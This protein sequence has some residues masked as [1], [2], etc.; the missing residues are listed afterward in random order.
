MYSYHITKRF[1]MR[2]NSSKLMQFL[3]NEV[4]E[5]YGTVWIVV[6]SRRIPVFELSC[7]DTKRGAEKTVRTLP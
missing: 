1:R 6:E 2:R 3:W 7:D 5:R 4:S